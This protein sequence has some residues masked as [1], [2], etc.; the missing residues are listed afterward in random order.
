MTTEKHGPSEGLGGSEVRSMVEDCGA[1]LLSACTSDGRKPTFNFLHC[2][3]IKTVGPT[4]QSALPATS[5][6]SRWARRFCINLA[7]RSD[8]SLSPSSSTASL[9]RSPAWFALRWLRAPNSCCSL[10]VST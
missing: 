9:R 8:L 3:Q 2:Q 10:A 1:L 7:D 5:K 6:E 4:G